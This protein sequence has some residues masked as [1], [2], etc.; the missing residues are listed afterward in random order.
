MSVSGWTVGIGVVVGAGLAAMGAGMLATGRMPAAT[1]R[2][3]RD[4][5]A[6]G[7]YH[8]LFGLALLILVVGL[9]LPGFAASWISAGVAVTLVAVA[10]VRYR[11]RRRSP[12]D[13]QGE[14]H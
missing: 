10:V 2:T 11:P 4:V 7:L 1:A 6:A 12:D 14:G 13:E 3:F 9:Y 8:L 5:R